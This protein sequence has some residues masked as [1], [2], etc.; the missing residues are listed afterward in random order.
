MSQPKNTWSK[1]LF[2]FFFVVLWYAR[3]R[4]VL[5]Q[6]HASSNIKVAWECFP[7]RIIIIVFYALACHLF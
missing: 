7:A 6:E 3:G 2:V 5:T 4:Q 1:P